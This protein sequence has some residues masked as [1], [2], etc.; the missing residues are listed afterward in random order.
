MTIVPEDF[1]APSF[2]RC[3]LPDVPADGSGDGASSLSDD[4]E[5]EVADNDGLASDSEMVG[6][7]GRA[8]VEADMAPRDLVAVAWLWVNCCFFGQQQV[9]VP[10]TSQAGCEGGWEH[11]SLQ[12]KDVDFQWVPQKKERSRGSQERSFYSVIMPTGGMR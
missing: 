2:G 9:S 1:R 7:A 6:T 8:S 3:S 12:F 10:P 5:D 4:A 11:Y